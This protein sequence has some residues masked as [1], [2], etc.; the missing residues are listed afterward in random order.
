MMRLMLLF[1]MNFLMVCVG[2]FGMMCLWMV[3]LCL[4]VVVVM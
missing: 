3:S 4:V 2:L 1:L